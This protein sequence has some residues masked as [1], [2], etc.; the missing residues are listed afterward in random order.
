VSKRDPRVAVLNSKRNGNAKH[1]RLIGISGE[2][3]GKICVRGPIDTI[4]SQR[5]P[6]VRLR[7]L[8]AFYSD[9]NGAKGTGREAMVKIDTGSHTLQMIAVDDRCGDPNVVELYGCQRRTNGGGPQC[10]ETRNDERR[11]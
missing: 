2:I 6:H 5:P 11:R 9:G 3:D 10:H 1:H 7:P 8:S 4:D